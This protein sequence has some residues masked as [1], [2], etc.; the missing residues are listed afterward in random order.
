MTTKALY[1]IPHETK[2]KIYMNSLSPNVVLPNSYHI[3]NIQYDSTGEAA[4]IVLIIILMLNLHT[5]LS[6]NIF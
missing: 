3:L 5:R 1:K 6:I 4:H 2:S